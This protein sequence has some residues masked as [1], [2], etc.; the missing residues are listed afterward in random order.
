ME[1]LECD[2][3][4]HRNIIIVDLTKIRLCFQ[5]KFPIPFL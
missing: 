3:A 5:D 4:K 2:F 1:N